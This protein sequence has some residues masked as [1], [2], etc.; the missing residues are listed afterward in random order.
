M[1]GHRGGVGGMGGHGGA[2][3]NDLEDD[4]MDG[5]DRFQREAKPHWCEGAVANGLLLA[6]AR[7]RHWEPWSYRYSWI[8][9]APLLNRG[10]VVTENL[11]AEPET[12]FSDEQSVAVAF[13]DAADQ[14]LALVDSHRADLEK[15]PPIPMQDLIGS[16][17]GGGRGAMMNFARAGLGLGMGGVGGGM[18]IYPVDSWMATEGAGPRSQGKS[19]SVVLVEYVVRAAPSFAAVVE[20]LRRCRD[21]AYVIFT[22]ASRVHRQQ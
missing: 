3:D 7:I 5:I 4:F 1:G 15:R 20:L 16:G 22:Q 17:G 11:L 19:D 18:L 2:G 8:K 14:I 9:A 12:Y 13:R 21:H 10:R 6:I